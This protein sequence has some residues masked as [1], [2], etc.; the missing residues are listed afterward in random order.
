MF[1]LTGSA[2]PFFSGAR[3]YLEVVPA[4]GLP[5]GNICAFV[6]S[7]RNLEL[8]EGRAQVWFTTVF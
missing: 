7:S 6:S 5:F 2:S 4:V 1:L 3:V 8:L